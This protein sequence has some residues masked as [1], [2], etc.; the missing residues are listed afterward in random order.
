MVISQ[1]GFHKTASTAS[2]GSGTPSIQSGKKI[3]VKIHLVRHGETEANRNGIVL[4]Q[5]DSPL[6]PLGM[7]QAKAGHAGYGKGKY[8]KIFSSDLKR[9]QH[10][11]RIIL[12]H[13]HTKVDDKFEEIMMEDNDGI[14]ILDTRL[15][16]R[17]KGVREGQS[18]L[19]SYDQAMNIYMKKIKGDNDNDGDSGDGKRAKMPLL[20]NDDEVLH[21]VIDWMQEMLQDAHNESCDQTIDH[22]DEYNILAISHS[23]TI[24]IVLENIVGEQLPDNVERESGSLIM[25]ENLSSK[26]GRLVVPNTSKSVIEFAMVNENASIDSFESVNNRFNTKSRGMDVSWTPNLIDCLNISHLRGNAKNT[27]D[28]E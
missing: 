14:L 12:G 23:G 24:R 3:S 1:E 6:T 11:A 13:S 22:Q 18:K 25:M 5:I 19:L 2:S 20:E 9:C 26:D 15:R 8:F 27:V 28:H 4:G 10:T 21:R 7:E 17:A 16:E